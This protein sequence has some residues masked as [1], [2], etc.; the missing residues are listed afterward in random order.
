MLKTREDIGGGDCHSFIEAEWIFNECFTDVKHWLNFMQIFN[1][2]TQKV[3][4]NVIN[5][6]FSICP[7]I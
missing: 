7:V 1:L 2:I 3:E 4:N 6:R 5:G